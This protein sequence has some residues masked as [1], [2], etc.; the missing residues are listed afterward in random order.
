MCK[1]STVK[2][3]IEAAIIDE[4]YVI[5][6]PYVLCRLEAKLNGKH[7]RSVM[8]AIQGKGDPFVEARGM[9]IAR[10]RAVLQLAKHANLL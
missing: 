4:E 10:G 9:E 8:H 5:L 3:Q 7:Y 6:R 2:S 1:R